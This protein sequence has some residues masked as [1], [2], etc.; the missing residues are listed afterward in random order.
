MSVV[1]IPNVRYPPGEES[2]AAADV[3]LQSVA[4]LTPDVVDE[5]GISDADKRE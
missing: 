3:V 1:A 5:K 4:E 2:L